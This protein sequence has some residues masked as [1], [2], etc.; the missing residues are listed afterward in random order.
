MLHGWKDLYQQPASRAGGQ[1]AKQVLSACTRKLER[2]APELLASDNACMLH[3][4][5]CQASR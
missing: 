3:R 2:S 4:Q 1:H 5:E